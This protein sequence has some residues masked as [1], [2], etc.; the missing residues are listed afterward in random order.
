MKLLRF[1]PLLA[2][3]GI[4]AGADNGEFFEA[5]V[6]P[7]LARNCYPCHTNSMMGGLRLDSADALRKGGKSGPPI[8]PGKPDESLLI[9][10]I[11]QTHALIRMPPSGK[12]TEREIADISEWVK[13]GAAWPASAKAPEAPQT[14]GYVIT[15]EHRAFWSF[16]PVRKPAVPQVKTKT[17]V[18]TPIDS[19]VLARLEEK[20]L[21]PSRPADKRVL[22]RRATVDLIGLLP[23]PEEVDEFVADR[24]PDAFAKVVDRLLASPRYGERWGRHWLDVARYADDKVSASQEEAYANA[25]R[26]RDWVIQS[27]NND[28]PFDTFVKAQIAGDLMPSDDPLQYNPA[29]GFYALSPAFM[30]DERVDATSRAF[31]GLTVGCAQCHDHKFDPIPQKDFYALQGIFANTQLNQIPLAPKEI[32]D[33]WNSRKS[34]MDR[35][36][37]KLNK[38]LDQQSETLGELLA[39]QTARYM[40][41]TRKLA[42]ADGLDAETLERWTNYLNGRKKGY[43]YLDRWFELVDRNGS[44]KEFES[45]AT[46][47]QAKVESVIE[48]KRAVDQR[49]IIKFGPNAGR[50]QANVEL[51]SL[52]IEKFTLHRDIYSK[53]QTEAGGL[54]SP[55]G[56]LYYGAGK[57]DRFL[58]GEW[59]RRLDTLRSDL[60]EMRKAL[61]PQYPFLEAIKDRGNPQDIRLAIRGDRNNPG[62][63]TPRGFVSILSRGAPRRFTN[64]SGRMELAEAIMDPENPLT[65]R[66]MVNRIWQHH[67]IRPIVE[68]PSNF[69]QMGSRPSNPELLDYLAARF[70]ENKWS[71]KAMHREIML[72]STYMLSSEN[73][74]ANAA[75]DADNRFVWRANWRRLD[76]ESLRDSLL[77]VSGNLDL[78]MGGPPVRFNDSN[79]RRAIY[80]FV[81]RWKP[82][83][84]MTLFDFPLPIQTAEQ[85]NVTNVPVQRLFLMNSA[86]VETQAKAFAARLSG[87]QTQKV[88]QAYRILYGRVPDAQELDRAL[89]FLGK[90]GW[91]EYA[92][93]LLNS[94]ELQWVN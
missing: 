45:A 67:F 65:A 49:N 77:Y 58:S 91:N 30:Q 84:T 4:A 78:T 89:S 9:Q 20:G 80:G 87:D 10:A 81:S 59:R 37:A 51:D 33:S 93:V 88:R 32:V 85:R 90:H 41:A 27:F 83:P 43:P 1:F 2:F 69:G 66:V 52:P 16:V 79:N 74:E 18:R 22:I 6:R 8:V 19:F 15:P 39:A 40:L 46:D 76:A 92:R 25:F 57:I 82:N 61:P 94:N 86:F 13:A 73:V 56:V 3:A 12:L 24:S 21:A 23:T 35:Q 70:V 63:V 72:S 14:S 36:S 64:G 68:T 26:Y 17:W 31:L 62:E 38:F 54:R 44:P 50:D 34:A 71:I 48:E 55:D 29:L 5:Q 60:A 28:M 42:P 53:S 7:V 11:R 75:V 47:F